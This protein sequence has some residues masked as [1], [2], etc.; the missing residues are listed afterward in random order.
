MITIDNFEKELGAALLQKARPYATNGVVLYIEE[1]TE[2]V[3]QAEVA[4]TETYTVEI[5]LEGRTVADAFC[6]CPVDDQYCKHVATVLLVLR[7][8]LAKPK[9]K[10]AKTPKKFTLN[11][12]LAKVTADELR[13]F[14]LAQAAADKVFSSKVQLH[15]ADKDERVDV[16]KQYADL[17]KKAVRAS[18]D[19]GFVDYQ[20]A[21]RLAREFDKLLESAILLTHKQNFRDAIIAGQVLAIGMMDVIKESD[22]SSGNIGGS[23]NEAIEFLHDLARDPSLAPALQQSLYEWSAK[24]LGQKTFADYGDYDYEVLDMAYNIALLLPDPSVFVGLLDD[25]IR[26]YAGKYDN[27]AQDRFK[28]M[29]VEFLRETGQTA[30]ADQLTEANLEIVA[31][32]DQVLDAAIAAGLWERAGELIQGGIQVAE[33]LG[34]PGTVRHWEERMLAVARLTNDLTTARRLTKEFAFN[35]Q[36]FNRTYYRQ[37]KEAFSAE[38]WSGIFDSLEN[39][40]RREEAAREKP[41]NLWQSGLEQ[42]LFRRLTPLFIEEEKWEKLLTLVQDYPK[43]GIDVLT[44]VHPHLASRYPAEM[45]ALYM[46][47]LTA[48]GDTVNGRGDY[49]KLAGWLGMVKKDVADSIPAIH[50][51]IDALKA[52]YPKRP[53]LQEELDTVKRQKA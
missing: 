6:D 25:L 11:S 47:R 19:R 48:F 8:E 52:K 42:N 4:G 31:I 46:P 2:N 40:I 49:Q 39:S 23:V 26:L 30:E 21:K 10:A 5:K 34:H 32:R 43:V 20:G 15:F 51:L 27:Y 29:K 50:T 33:K 28:T 41:K 22:D 36:G 13:A 17:L 37:W 44:Q 1:T 16:G 3:W 38:E 53:A 18:S 12:L 24:H 35:H 14:V 7:Q 9:A 45:L